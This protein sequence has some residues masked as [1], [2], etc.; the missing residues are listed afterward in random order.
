[1]KGLS[2]VDAI[3]ASALRAVAALQAGNGCARGEEHGTLPRVFQLQ[4]T[5]HDA[6]S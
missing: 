5:E 4:R 6:A 3:D 2:I 1:M